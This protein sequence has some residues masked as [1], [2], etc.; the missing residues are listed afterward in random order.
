MNCREDKVTKMMKIGLSIEAIAIAFAIVFV[1]AQ[2]PVPAFTAVFLVAGMA[3]CLAGAFVS[4]SKHM[5]DESEANDE[6]TGIFSLRK[7][8]A[9]TIVVAVVL[10]TVILTAVSLYPITT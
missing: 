3:I 7:S 1:V 6:K 5:K 8:V 4:Y 2:Q 10:L 9:Y